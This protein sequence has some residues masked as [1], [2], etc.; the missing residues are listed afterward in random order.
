[1]F[2]AYVSRLKLLVAMAAFLPILVI[3]LMAMPLHPGAPLAMRLIGAVILA[4]LLVWFL[5]A[6]RLLAL[7][8]PVIEM[9]AEGLIWRR[10]SARRIPWSA[11]ERWQVKSTLGI[12]FATLWLADRRAYP[13]LP[14]QRLLAIGNRWLGYGDLTL[15]ASGT[16]GEFADLVAALQQRLPPPLPAQPRLARRLT[17]ARERA[18]ARRP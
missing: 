17:R 1:M 15:N 4:P 12:P 18:Q 2:T 10:W 7:S 14:I 3:G 5:L 6:L 13:P 11:I 16:D 9:D 8:L